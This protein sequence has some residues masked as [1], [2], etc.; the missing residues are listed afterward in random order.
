MDSFGLKEQ[1]RA[2][3]SPEAKVPVAEAVKISHQYIVQGLLVVDKMPC[4]Q[5]TPGLNNMLYDGVI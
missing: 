2:L 3:M 1:T 5:G 4:L